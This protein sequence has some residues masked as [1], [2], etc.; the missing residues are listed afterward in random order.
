[1]R[2]CQEG[3]GG[4]LG[5]WESHIACLNFKGSRVNTSQMF[6][7]AVRIVKKYAICR[8]FTLSAVATF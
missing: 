8:D 5:G 4:G 6:H 7:I 2:P 1:M 3:G